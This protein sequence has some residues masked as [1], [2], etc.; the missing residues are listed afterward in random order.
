MSLGWYILLGRNGGISGNLSFLF[1]KASFINYSHSFDSHILKTW[2]SLSSVFFFFSWEI[3]KFLCHCSRWPARSCS[4]ILLFCSDPSAEGR[5]RQGLAGRG[6]PGAALSFPEP[7]ALCWQ[8]SSFCDLWNSSLS[9]KKQVSVQELFVSLVAQHRRTT[10]T[11]PR[12][13]HS[14][15]CKVFIWF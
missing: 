9:L 12:D 8:F 3:T 13:P 7:Q 4:R 10:Y 6:A 14:K 5:S 1:S 11:L 15:Q 2:G